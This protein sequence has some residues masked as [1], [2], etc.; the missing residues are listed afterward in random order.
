M[1]ELEQ[2]KAKYQELGAV[3]ERMGKGEAEFKPLAVGIY[4]GGN[5]CTGEESTPNRGKLWNIMPTIEDAERLGKIFQAVAEQEHLVKFVNG[6]CGKFVSGE[7]HGIFFDVIRKLFGT[8]KS[9]I[10]KD[11]GTPLFKDSTASERALKLASPNLLAYWKG[12]L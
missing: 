3:I 7:S 5:G 2:L 12:E 6:D 10:C 4:V 11:V 8:A 1:N 9:Q